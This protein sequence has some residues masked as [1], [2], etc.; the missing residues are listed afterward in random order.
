[1]KKICIIESESHYEVIRNL[2]LSIL[3]RDVEIDVITTKS[4]IENLDLIRN[5]KVRL[6]DLSDEIPKKVYDTK[7]TITPPSIADH[8]KCKSLF[9][10][11]ALVI[12]NMNYWL[13]PSGK[14]AAIQ[15]PNDRIK[16]IL[17]Y[18]KYSYASYQMRKLYQR[19]FSYY[20]AP[21]TELYR[22]YKHHPKLKGFLD[23]RY[24]FLKKEEINDGSLRIG[25]PGT[26]NH[27]RDY[28]VL[29]EL[30]T[31]AD[32]RKQKTL[33]LLIGKNER[34][35]QF[36]ELE[37][38]YFKVMTYAESLS[39]HEFTE[40][41]RTCDK[42]ILPLKEKISYRGIMER[43]GYSNIA[44]GVNDA[45]NAGIPLELPD[46]YTLDKVPKVG[47]DY[48]SHNKEVGEWNWKVILEQSE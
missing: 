10:G 18:I 43:K 7:L 42:I 40:L 30:A 21:S 45:W 46:F 17:R 9:E 11:S 3:D 23:L 31:K 6:Y 22:N 32:E 4:C 8:E 16:N 1:M 37:S 47:M 36:R 13:E 26:V 14:I 39:D 35:L 2:V 12:H 27:L 48:Q 15:I 5:A 41:L 33:V 34:K 28:S 29:S 19:T 24:H 25:I 44:G 20:L 38:S